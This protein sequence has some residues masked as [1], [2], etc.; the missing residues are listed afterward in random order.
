M[1]KPT[2][3][4]EEL[5][6]RM[7]IWDALNGRDGKAVTTASLV[8]ELR[9]FYGG[10]G[11]WR[12][13]PTTS[14]LTPDDKGIAVGILH[15]QSK[16]A[17]RMEQDGILYHYPVTRVPGTD[18]GDIA[19][20]KAAAK[21]RLPIFVVRKLKPHSSDR[22]V[23]LGWVLECHDESKFAL[24]EFSDDAPDP[25]PTPDTVNDIP[26]TLTDDIK[27]PPRSS[28]PS[29]PGQSRF[30][31]QAL[32][33]YGSRCP[34][35]GIDIVEVLDA[36]H[37]VDK[38]AFGTD[39]QRNSLLIAAHVH[40]AWDAGLFGIHPETLVAV[41]RGDGNTFD[42]LGMSAQGLQKCEYAP[43]HDALKWKWD[44]QSD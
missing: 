28:Q 37:V 21:F 41:D 36:A 10:R 8:N 39:D 11:V 3:I 32:K 1:A 18:H 12:D 17:D 33:R 2:N 22:I 40:R 30:K 15:T 31:F 5:S 35:T 23:H 24:I 27:P 44:R 34:F 26:F 19:G 38:A 29:R 9:A 6:R 14:P 20:L 13:M 42:K 25:L 16:Y 43:H 4:E 7:S